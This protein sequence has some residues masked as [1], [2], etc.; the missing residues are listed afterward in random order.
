MMRI[1]VVVALACACHHE[2]PGRVIVTDT[3]I[4][5]LGPIRFPEQSIALDTTATKMLDAVASTLVGNPSILIVSVHAYGTGA[6]PEG[7]Q[8]LADQRTDAIVQ[9]LVA[10]GVEA[11]R[12]QSGGLTDP[13]TPD[14]GVSLEIIKRKQ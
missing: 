4:E 5:I 7:R 2:K 12:L 3:S 10:H 9:Y 1:A 13:P 8:Q 11:N 14:A 6:P